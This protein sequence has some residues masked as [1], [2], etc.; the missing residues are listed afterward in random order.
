MDVTFDPC[1]DL[2]VAVEGAGAAERS[3]VDEAVALWNASGPLRLTRDESVDL[4][5]VSVSFQKAAAAFRGVYDDERGVVI[6]NEGISNERTRT[7]TVAHELG[8]SFGLWH[9]SASDGASVMQADNVDVAPT[10]GDV[11]RLE[12]LWESCVARE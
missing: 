7:I 4:P 1:A 2:L 12:Q 5:R 6:V 11:E 9:A 8:H 10:A 3:A